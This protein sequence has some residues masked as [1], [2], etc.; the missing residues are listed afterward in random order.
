VFRDRFFGNDPASIGQYRRQVHDAVDALLAALPTGP[1]AG[2]LPATR[3]PFRASGT[4]IG[5]D[6]ALAAARTVVAHSVA[7][8]D[9]RTAAHLHCPVLIPALAA[10]TILAALNQSMDSFDQ[11]PAATAIEQEVVSWLC[12]RAGLPGAASGTFTAGGTQSNYMGLLLSTSG[13]AGTCTATGCPR[14]PGG[15]GSSARRPRTSASR[16][17]RFSSVSAP[18]AL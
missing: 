10:E 3:A 16:R 12:E 5:P 14:T 7:V 18:A 15:S 17:A 13:A 2:P 6:G 9:P 11:A 8:W 1:Y 4:G